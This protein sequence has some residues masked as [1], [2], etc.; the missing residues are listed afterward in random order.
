MSCNPTGAPPRLPG[1][2]GGGG[3][4]RDVCDERA[5][6]V[7]EHLTR[8]AAAESSENVGA[9]RLIVGHAMMWYRS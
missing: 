8:V 2:Q 3:E 4:P 9:V 1:R 7:G 6:D 5:R